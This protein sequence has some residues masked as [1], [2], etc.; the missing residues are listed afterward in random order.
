[1]LINESAERY[2]PIENLPKAV[3]WHLFFGDWSQSETLPGIKP[4]L[5]DQSR[6]ITAHGCFKPALR[7]PSLYVVLNIQL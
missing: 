1:M 5:K 7:K 3:I 2:P 6:D 4:P